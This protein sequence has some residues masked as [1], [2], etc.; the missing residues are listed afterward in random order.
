MR[1][2]LQAHF[3]GHTPTH[4]E[5]AIAT[6]VV[7]VI[8]P[9]PSDRDHRCECEIHIL[10]A[11]LEFAAHRG[12]HRVAH[13]AAAPLEH[14]PA[15]DEHPGNQAND[16]RRGALAVV[17]VAHGG[18]AATDAHIGRVGHA[19]RPVA[20]GLVSNPRCRLTIDEHLVRALGNELFGHRWVLAADRLVLGLGNRSGRG[21]RGHR[22]V[23]DAVDLL[24]QAD[25]RQHHRGADHGV[26]TDV[27]EDRRFIGW[28]RRLDRATTHSGGAR[29]EDTVDAGVVRTTADR[30]VRL[31]RKQR[32]ADPVAE[33]A[34][35]VANAL[36]FTGRQHGG[37]TDHDPGNQRCE[38]GGGAAGTDHSDHRATDGGADRGDRR[39]ID[40]GLDQA[41]D[42]L[43]HQRGMKN[44]IAHTGGMQAIVHETSEILAQC[45]Q[46]STG[47]CEDYRVA[48]RHFGASAQGLPDPVET[49]RPC[50]EGNVATTPP[51]PP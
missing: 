13:P 2:T 22:R 32:I 33:V 1:D 48:M 47:K 28:A 51:A 43:G 40:G 23:E 7:T 37:G 29:R 17:D 26:G 20:G 34:D 16:L 18:G 3:V 50:A 44:E 36:V 35:M 8:A 45:V 42:Q 39:R 5:Q 9:R 12:S 10:G 14:A 49:G 25:H 46:R 31:G 30:A 19:D 41:T 6:P 15:T 38:H 11:V 4:A 21:R 24:R 27:F